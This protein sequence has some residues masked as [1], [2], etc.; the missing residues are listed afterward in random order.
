MANAQM[1][2]KILDMIEK[3][4]ENFDMGTWISNI[5]SDID[6]TFGIKYDGYTG[7]TGLTRTLQIVESDGKDTL[8]IC[9][10][11]L[12]V[13]GWA[14]AL[15]GWQFNRYGTPTKDGQQFDSWVK[16]GMKI[17]DITL[18]D[19]E[20]LF[21]TSDTRAVLALTQLAEGADII[22]WDKVNDEDD[23]D[24]DEYDYC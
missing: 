24:D 15:D 8:N 20:V 22:D 16:T 17:L 6:R 13:S 23:D 2:R 1:A 14:L 10:T 4:P 11:T 19:A 5:D 18:Y 7:Y 21:G 3:Y 12:C 9:D